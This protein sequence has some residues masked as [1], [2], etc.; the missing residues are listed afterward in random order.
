VVSTASYRSMITPA[1]LAG[2]EALN[3]GFGLVPGNF[4]GVESI[5][6]GGGQIG[7]S[8]ALSYYPD[9]DL[10][11]AVLANHETAQAANISNQLSRIV[12]G[13]GEPVVRDVAVP[14][15]Q[16][17]RYPGTYDIGGVRI[18]VLEEGGRL[19]I[20]GFWPSPMR[21]LATGDDEF[22]AQADPSVRVV[23]RIDND[24]AR[25]LTLHLSGAVI[26]GR[27]VE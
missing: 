3:Y 14:P 4:F 5:G 23:F 10:A 27:R 17:V 19:V 22:R 8:A 9:S 1:A 2:G 12:L 18:R 24:R 25:L 7:Y 13:L 15:A 11:I 20:Q 21:L 16:R 6:H 26:E